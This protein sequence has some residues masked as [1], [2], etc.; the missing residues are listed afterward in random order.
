VPDVSDPY[1]SLP[2]DNDEPDHWILDVP[3]DFY[4]DVQAEPHLLYL[5]QRDRPMRLR[6]F[7]GFD[8]VLGMRTL[9]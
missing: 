6:P 4:G 8:E 9:N 1:A 5:T 7:G 3:D 2:D